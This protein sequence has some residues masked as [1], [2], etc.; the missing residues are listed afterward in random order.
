MKLHTKLLIALILGI[1]IGVPMHHY[2]DNEWINVLNTHFLNPIAQIFLRLI[3]MIV[4][5]M[6]TSALILGVFELGASRGLGKV[7][8]R[9]LSYTIITSTASVIIGVTLVNIF[10]PGRGLQFD[11]AALEAQATTVD[12]IKNNAAA[13]KSFSQSLVEII[14][15]N[16]LDAAV[17]ALDGEM[18]SL[19]V[20]SLLFGL[21][22]SFTSNPNKEQNPMLQ[23]LE[24]VFNA[25]M[26]IV[27]YAMKLAP[28]AVF[29]L[30]FNTAF[31]FGHQIF[32]SLLFYV[33]IVVVGL[34]IQ[35]CGVLGTVKINRPSFAA[36]V[37][38]LLPRSIS[39]SICHCV[40]QCNLA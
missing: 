4:V 10:Q 2:V 15:K 33:V 1:A 35:I 17:R 7:A 32:L 20:F 27:S 36:G 38:S 23:L 30:V 22:L 13:A 5:P 16:P 18:I 26:K 21:A 40:F 8:G 37:F 39:H 34:L 19:M 6:V 11:K 29:A 31:K 24:A 28:Y 9:T 3:F 14:P 12:K 25:C